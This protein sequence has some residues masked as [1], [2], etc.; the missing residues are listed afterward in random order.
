METESGTGRPASSFKGTSL[1]L[2]LGAGA[3]RASWKEAAGVWRLDGEVWGCGSLLLEE[4][5][6]PPRVLWSLF[7]ELSSVHLR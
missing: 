5:P 1:T 4:S 6:A 2:L 3:L 7:W